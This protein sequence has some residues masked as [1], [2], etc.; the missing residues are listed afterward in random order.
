MRAG[1]VRGQALDDAGLAAMLAGNVPEWMAAAPRIPCQVSASIDGLTY[2]CVYYVKQNYLT[3]GEDD[4]WGTFPLSEVNLQAWCDKTGC[5]IPPKK[6]IRDTWDRT[7]CKIAP[8]NIYRP[9][10]GY[11]G[12]LDAGIEPIA[13]EQQ[14]INEA[15]QQKGC[16]VN[17]FSRAKKAYITAPNMD[18]GNLHFTGWYSDGITGYKAADPGLANS[19]GVVQPPRTPYGRAW[20]DGDDAS[21]PARYADYSHGCDVVGPTVSIN[22]QE[23]S[24]ADVCAHPK[25]HVLVSDQGPFV[26]RFPNANLKPPSPPAPMPNAPETLAS[27]AGPIYKTNSAG[28]AVLSKAGQPLVRYSVPNAP[29]TTNSS[30][31]PASSPRGL[32]TILGLGAVAIGAYWYWKESVRRPRLVRA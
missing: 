8:Q 32:L 19:K 17:S 26:P 22:D 28:I 15:M 10:A 5:F 23:Y 2:Y 27:F 25:L 18:G 13:A 29:A 16:S 3:I 9:P 14:M 6:I 4:D 21:H 30:T 7:D 11:P 12:P 20:Q 1:N 24:F 31:S